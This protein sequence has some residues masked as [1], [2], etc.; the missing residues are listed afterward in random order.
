MT[1][2]R[3]TAHRP[4]I[5]HGFLAGALLAVAAL[6]ATSGDWL[7][8]GILA[9]GGV[10]ELCVLLLARRRAS[11]GAAHGDRQV[12]TARPDAAALQR[13]ERAHHQALRL[14]TALVALTS[15]AGVALVTSA[16]SLAAVLGILALV[17]LA[18]L[19]R[20]RRSVARLQALLQ[21]RTAGQVA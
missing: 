4:R 9:A 7:W 21:G 20:E 19:R 18:R 14:W 6:R 2:P 3:T 8:A 5:R 1:H 11:E 12:R 10:A 15:V 16:P 17:A 13:S